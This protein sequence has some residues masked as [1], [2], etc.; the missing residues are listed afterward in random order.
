ML[1]AGVILRTFVCILIPNKQHATITRWINERRIESQE[2]EWVEPK[3]MHITLKFCGEN[4]IKTINNI[5]RH[6]ATIKQTG[7]IT[8]FIEGIGGFPNLTYPRIIWGAVNGDIDQLRKIQKN[9]DKATLKA[10]VESNKYPFL[11]HL[12]LGRIRTEDILTKVALNAIKKNRLAV[13]P[14]IVNE[15]VLMSS[16]ICH[17]R[18]VLTPIGLFKI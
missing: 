5:K 9:V 6:L 8:L 17:T 2:I 1:S 7:N 18:T 15:I 11:P 12:T 16:T 4:D 13:E 14:W 10:G 3:T